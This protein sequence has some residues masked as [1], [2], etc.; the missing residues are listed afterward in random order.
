MCRT[1]DNNSGHQNESLN[2][3][4]S[5]LMHSHK[6]DARPLLKHF[7][8]YL[9]Y[10]CCMQQQQ[11]QGRGQEGTKQIS[12]AKKNLLKQTLNK[13]KDLIKSFGN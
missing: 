2:P 12:F 6:A 5:G 13:D 1:C 3:M 7:N 10:K 11:M 4:T 9:K 8:L